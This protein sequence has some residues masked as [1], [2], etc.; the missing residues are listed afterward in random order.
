MITITVRVQPGASKD[1]VVGW[2]EGVLKIRLRAR[3]VEGKANK[4]LV[5]FLSSALGLR[6][7][8]VAL[9]KGEKSRQKL[10]QVDLPSLEE[11]DARLAH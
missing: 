8:Q 2:E 11:V 4:S 1:E 9:I 3:A 10:V 6:S 7:R 5:D